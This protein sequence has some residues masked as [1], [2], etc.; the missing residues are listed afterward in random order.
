MN[1]RAAALAAGTALALCGR[2]AGQTLF[3]DVT[4]SL[5]QG[6]P[7]ICR[8]VAWGDY[9]ND[10]WID[11]FLAE[12]GAPGERMA[13]W[14]QAG[15]RFL[16][17]SADLPVTSFP[18]RR[19]R[20]S[21]WGDYD[22]DGDLDVF[23]TSGT[24]G[25]ACGGGA[26]PNH[27]LRNDLGRFTEVTLEAGLTDVLPTDDALWLD[28]DR[29]GFLDLYTGNL[30]VRLNDEGTEITDEGAWVR[31]KLY[32]NRGDG[33]FAD[34]T[35]Q[36]GLDVQLHRLGGGS[37][38][39]MTAA[40]LND[41]GWPDL[42]MGVYG[43]RNRLFLSDGQGRFRDATT[44]E[45]GDEGAAFDVTV[46]D[47]DNDGDLDLFQAAG[48]T[49]AQAFRSL[50][51]VNLGG[52]Q[53][54]DATESAGLGGELSRTELQDARFGDLDNDGDLDLLTG[55]P[56]HLY[57]NDGSGS[58]TEA[59]ER[60]GIT[61]NPGFLIL[62]DYDRDGHL[63]ACFGLGDQS[64]GFGGLYRNQGNANHWLEVEVVGTVS[65]RT[66][67][68]ARVIA[69]S[70]AV[71]QTREIL[72]GLGLGQDEMVAHF[73]LADRTLVDRLEVRWPSGQVDVFTGVAADQRIRVVEGQPEYRVARAATATGTDT[74]VVGVPQDFALRVEPA[75]LH[76]GARV[77][78][79]VADLSGI[80]GGPE[81]LMQPE[82]ESGY[83]LRVALPAPAANEL[84]VV[85]VLV[86]QDTPLGP[87]W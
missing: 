21:C 32:R 27:L 72:G 70:G 33:S 18:Q 25:A 76:G 80:G 45:I 3:A 14:R 71:R 67:I 29:D 61:G 19:G 35:E 68:G 2:A 52:G 40:D 16:D 34:V 49:I 22:N 41:D 84:A 8:S 37:N 59:T 50:L 73:G 31:N 64:V 38:G 63:D 4:V 82:G 10:G 12:N 5:F 87:P 62:G 23:V 85:P 28:Y 69:V 9:D 75:T 7:F 20:G 66:G 36:V 30:D 57:L 54:V 24:C 74:L 58:F 42:Y 53:L 56:H 26:S 17:A 1:A 48:G 47:I 51:L 77:T 86:E 55:W 6:V 11:L 13:L 15:G 78:R 79:V 44:E 83:S 46:G 65:N 81:V 39:G 60:S 43:D